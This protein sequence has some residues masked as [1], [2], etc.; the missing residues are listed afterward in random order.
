MYKSKLRKLGM[1]A[2]LGAGLLATGPA[3]AYN[4]RLGD[5]DIQIDTTASVGLSFRVADR[6]TDL[7]PWVNGGPGE[8]L[9]GV[10]L[11]AN[12]MGTIA[13]LNAACK[14]NGTVCMAVTSTRENSNYD[15]SIN[16]D[17]GRLNFDNGD[18]TA[19]TLKIVSDIEADFGFAR[20]FA[21]VR[22]F[23][24]AV[25]DSDSSFERSGIN[26]DGEAE[27]IMHIDLLDA[28]VDFDLDVGNMPVL[29]RAGK[30]VI[31]W[32]EST[33]VLG[34]NSVFSPIDVGAIRRPGSEIKEALLPV[35]ALYVSASPTDALTVEAYIGGH[36]PFIID[37]G[38]TPFAGSDAFNKGSNGNGNGFYIGGAPSSGAGRINCNPA[39]DGTAAGGTNGI[40]AWGTAISQFAEAAYT[41]A[42]GAT[43]D[44]SA[45]DYLYAL[46]STDLGEFGGT[47]P[48][49]QRLAYDDLYFI[50]R[51]FDEE[52]DD[53]DDI[54]LALRYYSERLNSTEF[55]LYFQKV[56]SRIPYASV[57][58]LG[59][60]AGWT[61]V[62]T[63]TDQT[64]RIA[65]T[66]GCMVQGAA[67]T[68]VNAAFAGEAIDDPEGILDSA[69]A[70]T[71]NGTDLSAA[72]AGL[73]ADAANQALFDDDMSE[74]DAGTLGRYQQ[75]MCKGHAMNLAGGNATVVDTAVL[76]QTGTMNLAIGFPLELVAEYPEVET[77]GASFATTLLGWGVQGEIAYREEMPVSL[78]SNSVTIAG[79]VGGCAFTNYG[80]G[81][82]AVIENAYGVAVPI[83]A[84]FTSLSTFNAEFGT[85]C[86]GD[87]QLHSGFALE[88]VYNWDIGTTATYTRSNPVIAALG[89]DLGVLLT[90][91]AGVHAPDFEDHGFVG[92]NDRL[93]PTGVCTSGSDL[94]LRGLFGLDERSP[95]ECRP[96]RSAWGYV[97]LAQLQYNNVFGTPVS[98]TPRVVY[99][100]GAEGFALRPAAGWVED[101]STLGLSV[102]AAYQSNLTAS[103]SYTDY[104]GDVL[105]NPNID[106]DTVSLSLVY[107]F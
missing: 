89:A 20:G 55:G 58:S 50:A 44:N 48:E 45:I 81:G 39:G 59:P 29:I 76:A 27:A 83:S 11:G 75:M 104:Q 64:N 33:F 1:S 5:V 94:A 37:V 32:G 3:N 36:D 73:G 19:G 88:E 28:Y 16:N 15:A 82:D 102:T 96:T 70:T 54:G 90:E 53:F 2:L 61:T 4:M 56:N 69:L 51:G 80:A 97:L 41:A 23:Y 24:D 57:R 103:L 21:R 77:I 106:R 79:V 14:L 34:G 91:F 87:E 22:G 6:E 49:Q 10:T 78:D 8:T 65:G 26:E 12:D 60:V 40:G 71:I 31:N 47:I 7:L 99:S 43:C 46:G 107:G 38:G 62:G 92:E 9:R 35:E 86:S 52:E 100:A 42:N 67:G 13:N 95:E 18:L 72:V 84:F 74:T 85:N 30:Q 93:R 66:M 105:Y 63:T 25:L 98:L 17:D 68:A 101:Q